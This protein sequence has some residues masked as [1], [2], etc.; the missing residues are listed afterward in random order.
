MAVLNKWFY[1]H[2]H[3]PHPNFDQKIALAKEAGINV[4]QVELTNENCNDPYF[5]IIAGLSLNR[6]KTGFLTPAKP[7]YRPR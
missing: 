7:N 4:N 6:S 1:N 3:D 5:L 2:Y